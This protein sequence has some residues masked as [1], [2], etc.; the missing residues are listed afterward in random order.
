[1][2]Q[3]RQPEAR[4]P[5]HGSRPGPEKH[6]DRAAEIQRTH[7]TR[8]LNIKCAMYLQGCCATAE[9]D[10]HSQYQSNSGH[11]LHRT[12]GDPRCPEQGRTRMVATK[13]AAV[14]VQ[15]TRHGIPT[16]MRLRPRYTGH[17]RGVRGPARAW[18][19][20]GLYT[21]KHHMQGT[22]VSGGVSV[23]PT[24]TLVDVRKSPEPKQKQIK[25]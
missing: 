12:A 2:H 25:I 24:E 8:R 20:W 14:H 5:A 23:R 4:W 7:A 9:E 18:P 16:L 22:P 17:G 19:G 6:R 21:S 13:H 1:M 10:V 11:G 3:G 15:H